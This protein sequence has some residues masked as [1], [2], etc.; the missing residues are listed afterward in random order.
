MPVLLPAV[1]CEM[2]EAFGYGYWFG[3][4]FIPVATFGLLP[5]V[6][7]ATA[8]PPSKF[9]IALCAII[10]YLIVTVFVG[11]FAYA[12]IPAQ[13]TRDQRWAWPPT[14]NSLGEIH[15]V[16]LERAASPSAV[17]P[18]SAPYVR[19]LVRDE[20]LTYLRRCLPLASGGFVIWMAIVLLPGVVRRSETI[21]QRYLNH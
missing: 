12:F 2:S 1:A 14:S 5:L 4:L 6:L 8:K 13:Y 3:M 7:F 16:F 18:Q 10:G 11:L 15:G 19:Q 9:R 17:A 21:S 20:Q